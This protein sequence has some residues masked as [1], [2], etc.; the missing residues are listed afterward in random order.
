MII[1]R[2]LLIKSVTLLLTL[3]LLG[4]V[5]AYASEVTGTLISGI[6]AS[7]SQVEGSLGGTVSGVSS[8][9]GSVSGGSGGGG[10][11]RGSGGGS[12]N[13]GSH[14][15]TVLGSSTGGGVGGGN[16]S[17]SGSVLGASTAEGIPSFPNAG[18]GPENTPTSENIISWIIIGIT[19]T[20]LSVY[21]SVKRSS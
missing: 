7:S 16:G 12:S 11:S 15:G 3:P 18:L 8:V 14:S 5:P 9:S 1:F 10:G 13:G 2:K 20:A 4:L 6:D 17:P 21:R 19:A